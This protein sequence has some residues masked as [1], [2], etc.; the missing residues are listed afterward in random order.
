MRPLWRGLSGLLAAPYTPNRSLRGQ[1]HT[2]ITP[3][4]Y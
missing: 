1:Y 4:P 2:T 3:T